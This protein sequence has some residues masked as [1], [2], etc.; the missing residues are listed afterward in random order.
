MKDRL[1]NLTLVLLL[2]LPLLAL[3]MGW[4]EV[5]GILERWKTQEQERYASQKL[6]EVAANTDL[7]QHLAEYALRFR[8]GMLSLLQ[9]YPNKLI[10]LPFGELGQSI[11]ARPF[12]DHVLWAF[13]GRPNQDSPEVAFCS[14]KAVS[15]RPMEMIFR[16]LVL[17]NQEKSRGSDENRRNEKLLQKVFGTCCTVQLLAGFQRGIATPV[18]YN[19]VP[20]FLVW[21]YGENSDGNMAGFFIIVPRNQDLDA[22]ALAMAARKTSLGAEVSGGFVKIFSAGSP[23][24]LFPETIGRSASFSSWR[25]NLGVA[26]EKLDE[27]ERNG[28]PWGMRLGNFRLYTRI[29]PAERHLALLLL[30]AVMP[31]HQ[32][33]WLMMVNL[34]CVAAV[35]MV[36]LR[37]LI[38]GI[39][40]FAS[41]NSRFAVAFL[42][43]ATLPSALFITSATAYVFERYKADENNLEETLVTSFSDFD[44]GKEAL[45]NDYRTAFSAMKSDAGIMGILAEQGVG[46]SQAVFARLRQIAE[47]QARNISISGVA[48]YDLAGNLDSDCRGNIRKVDFA[49]IAKFYGLPFTLNLRKAVSS[50]EPGLVLPEHKIDQNNLIAIQ[51]FKRGNDKLENELERYRNK[52]VR[53]DFGRGYLDYIYDFINIDGRNRFVLMVAWLESDID[54]QVIQNSANQLGIKAPQIRLAAFK[55]TANGEETILK[56]DRAFSAE[57]LRACRRISD[58]AFSIKSGVLKTS[59]AGMS[60]VAYASRHFDRTVLLGAIDHALKNSD[61]NW[62]VGIFML[63]ALLAGFMLFASALALWIRI[64]KP[65]KSI[66]G[67]FD[68]VEGGSLVKLPVAERADEIGLLQSEFNHMIH[69]LEERHRLAS[70]LSEH[71]VAAVANTSQQGRSAPEK[72]SGVV[73]ISDIRSFTTMCEQHQ[74]ELVTALLNE[75]I[76]CMATVI[77]QFGGKIYK[78]IGDAIEAVFVD[79][80]R[81]L[82]N[83]GLRAVLA[84][85]AMLQKLQEINGQ[86][87]SA[88]L[89]VYRIGV[90]LAA[91]ELIAGEIGSQNS[92]RDYAMF[93]SAF[94]RAEEFEALTRHF[95]D[96]PLIADHHVVEASEKSTFLWNEFNHN[97]EYVF[98]LKRAPIDSSM[99]P[100]VIQPVEPESVSLPAVVTKEKPDTDE[101]Q[102]KEAVPWRGLIF[103][104]GLFCIIFPMAAWV[105]SGL[106]SGEALRSQD[107]K[108]ARDFCE[109]IFARLRVPDARQVFLEQYLDDL[110]EDMCDFPW[111]PQGVEAKALRA[112]G[113][114]MLVKLKSTGLKPIVATVLHKPGGAD[115]TELNADWNLLLPAGNASSA[116]LLTEY[117][118]TLAKRRYLRSYSGNDTL[119][120]QASL[121]LGLSMELKYFFDDAYARV[122]ET[123]RDGRES[124]LYWQPLFLRNPVLLAELRKNLSNP[125]LRQSPSERDVLQ[126]GGVLYQFFKEDIKPCFLSIL[127]QVLTRENVKFA[128][129]GADGDCF[130]SNGFPLGADAVKSG[131]VPSMP[132]WLIGTEKVSE[133]D[134][135]LMIAVEIRSTGR[136]VVILALLLTVLAAGFWYKSVFYDVFIA[137]NFASQLW[138]GLFAAAVVPITCVY[139]VNEWFAIEQQD[140]KIK[141][142]RVRIISVFE[143]LERRQFMQEIAE[144]EK[145]RDI[146][147]SE[148]F[149]RAVDAVDKPTPANL[150]K[151]ETVVRG[152][153]DVVHKFTGRTSFAEMVVFSSRGWQHSVYPDDI[154]RDASEFKRFINGFLTNL[155]NDM[156]VY[157]RASSDDN[158]PDGEAVKNE[159]TRDAGLQIFRTMFGVDAYFNLVHGLN[160]SMKLF[161]STGTGCLMLMPQPDMLRPDRILFWMFYDTLNSAMRRTFKRAGTPFPVYAEAKS[162]YGAMK[163]PWNCGWEPDVSRFA[164][165]SLAARA[166]LS[167]RGVFAGRNCLV[168]ARMGSHNETMIMVA[169][170]P[171]DDILSAIENS[172]QRFLL[173]LALS[174]LAIALLTWLVAADISLPVR[175]LIAGVQ[176]MAAQQFAF[177]IQ[178][179]RRD[180]LGQML[181]AFNKMAQGL[182]ERELM[183]K[184]VSRAALRVAGDEESL[185]QAEAGKHLQVTVMYLSVPGF[186]SL[187]DSLSPAELLARTSVQIDV[188]CGIIMN[189]DGEADK[190]IGEKILAYFYSP[191]G[192]RD[193]NAMAMHA[194]SLIDE[195]AR[196]GLLPFPVAVGLHA[197]DIIAGLLGISSKRDFTIIGDTVNT[198]ARINAKAAEL[199]ADRYLISEALARAADSYNTEAHGSVQLKGKADTVDLLRV[200]FQSSGV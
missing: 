193:S 128:I 44:A 48:V 59:A 109:S 147:D 7:S 146:S 150:K 83:P 110:S 41:I 159:M 88:G 174:L 199:S 194:L 142:E 22:A 28:F 40:P 167:T 137:R 62:R 171:E 12:P 97:G 114:T 54:R 65:L 71:A 30:P 39:W 180:E 120:E 129:V 141:E 184:M 173:L 16:A 102:L 106:T 76:T 116:L 183:G 196:D 111:S 158:K 135:Q 11:F 6:G 148:E 29:L 132:G 160:R 156:G 197:G 80:Y 57:Q 155:F 47:S 93:G 32:P 86:R 58:S 182:Q 185:R 42:L 53:T 24:M 192:L 99:P 166:P 5:S 124:Y 75:H 145:I 67:A 23:D 2:F 188:L 10:G 26:R 1:S 98:S 66:K 74:A 33:V 78:F 79:D 94:K 154:K 121:L 112:A 55:R 61:H 152:Q 133:Q 127:K 87:Q 63:L 198:A 177:R 43:A 70:M 68:K 176:S 56:P 3:N 104:A 36:I 77:N 101:N 143:Q 20:S 27:W 189:N 9:E 64:V 191:A 118:K 163:Q 187:H 103:L 89:F 84:G 35:M 126:I 170:A 125:V 149:S 18:I 52:V 91:G 72:F 31:G 119:I 161:Y 96:W 13:T 123:R 130:V 45:E 82:Q 181:Q 69:G 14:E 195:A 136:G 134:C 50:E 105:F 85:N 46:G 51:A 175:N 38:L 151:I 162:S 8:Q 49:T 117:L 186:N 200:R 190:I 179:V 81:F 90:G 153:A 21:D 172:R 108:N 107:E 15:R 113:E 37:G 157:G 95:P 19:R 60:V 34:W 178:T 115:V 168:E 92:R 164:R 100:V 139:T 17:E 4:R 169:M 138:L 140:L 73:M 144:W 122:I 25:N 165:W 131:I